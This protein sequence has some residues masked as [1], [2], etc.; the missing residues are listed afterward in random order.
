MASSTA[1]CWAQR[2]VPGVTGL[3][4]GGPSATQPYSCAPRRDCC[5]STRTMRSRPRLAR[6]LSASPRRY[7]TDARPQ[8][9][10]RAAMTAAKLLE[11]KTQRIHLTSGTLKTDQD[12][13][14]WLAV[15][16]KDLLAKLENGPVVIS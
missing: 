7:R 9:F 8:Q 3:R 6:Q 11:P 2:S 5:A 13:K 10:A 14:A 16:E 4:Q 12:V 15:T 1:E